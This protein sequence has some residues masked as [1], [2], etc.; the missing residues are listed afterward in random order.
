MS[1]QHRALTVGRKFMMEKKCAFLAHIGSDP[2][3]VHNNT[4]KE[5]HTLL[6]QPNH[7]TNF[8]LVEHLFVICPPWFVAGSATA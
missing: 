3:S 5:C 7:I 2:C 4:V 6:H 8:L 1:L